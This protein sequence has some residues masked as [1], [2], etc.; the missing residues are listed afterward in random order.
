MSVR[1]A[2]DGRKPRPARPP[3]PTGAETRETLFADAYKRG[4]AAG[5]DVGSGQALSE[6]KRLQ[7][8]LFDEL[9]PYADAERRRWELRGQPRTRE[10]FSRPH[11]DDFRGG[12]VQPW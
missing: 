5:A 4:F 6:V 8:D 11:P 3:Q 2:S 1:P 10:T 7:H 9:S 12:P